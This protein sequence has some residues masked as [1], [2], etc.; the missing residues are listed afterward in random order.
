MGLSR[1]R[2][3][4]KHC[5]AAYRPACIFK[6]THSPVGASLLAMRPCQST[7]MLNVS[8]PS[9]AGSLPQLDFWRA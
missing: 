4:Q 7:S 9:R 6:R 1:G 5:E 3:P 2:L 8:P